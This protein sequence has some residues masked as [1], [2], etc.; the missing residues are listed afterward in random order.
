[1]TPLSKDQNLRFELAVS[2]DA[3]EMV[4]FHNRYYDA[5]RTAEQ[6]LWEWQTHAP[7]RSVI[8]SLRNQNQ[9]IATFGV[10]PLYMNFSGK[11]VW[12]GKTESML[13]LPEYRGRGIATRL[14]KYVESQ[15]V[16][17]EFQFIWGFTYEKEA[18]IV[19]RML[20]YT[21]FPTIA[22]ATCPANI[23]IE[24]KSRLKMKANLWIRIGSAAKLVATSLFV[25]RGISKYQKQPGY[26]IKEKSKCNEDDIQGL[27]ERLQNKHRNT[28]FIK[29]DAKYL[30]WRV[31]EHPFL[32]Y[33]EY[34]V[35]QNGQMRAYA[36]VTIFDGTASISDLTSEDDH[37]TCLLLSTIIKRYRGKAGHFAYLCN[38][39]DTIAQDTLAQ[40]YK[41][42]FTLKPH[43]MELLYK[44]LRADKNGQDFEVQSWHITGFWTEG[45]SM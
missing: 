11:N 16:G 1:M 25:N 3:L 32:K 15:C 45:Y 10:I 28:T 2:K 6:W 8:A 13:L 42:G 35:Y 31:R 18:K 43:P 34:Q 33:D 22:T 20:G 21:F 17:R 37:A 24:A 41:L 7:E 36:F 38:P 19:F 27:Y 12:V 30:K 40:F 9:L 44:D 4:N 29:L 5:A 26:E 23:M 39:K 14:Y